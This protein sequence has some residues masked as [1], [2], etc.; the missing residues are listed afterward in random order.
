[1]SLLA[2]MFVASGLDPS[3]PERPVF[4]APAVWSG[5][6]HLVW[7]VALPGPAV[8]SASRTE[9]APPVV[10]DD[11]IL[12]GRTGVNGVLVLDRRDGVVRGTLPTSAPVAC[13]PL[14]RDGFVY[15]ADTSGQLHAFKR[16]ALDLAR[17][18]WTH[19]GGAPVLSTPVP[20]GQDLLVSNVSAVVYALDAASGQLRWRHAHALEATRA[21]A[22]PLYGA[23]A[24][25]VDTSTG[26]VYAG[27]R[28]GVVDTLDLADGEL[29]AS[30]RASEG[31]YGD[32][33]APV[34]I[35]A[36]NVVSGGFAGPIIARPAG[37]E[38][39]A[40]RLEVGN[41][42]SALVAGDALLHPGTDGKLRSVDGRTGDV[43]WTWDAG[44]DSTLSAPVRAGDVFIVGSTT[45]T[46]HMVATDGVETWAFRPDVVPNGFSASVAVDGGTMYAVSNSGVLYAF[47]TNPSSD[48]T[49]P[50]E[51]TNWPW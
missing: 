6:P 21:D 4:E 29:R 23:P 14:V 40:W 7:S 25:A 13:A 2:A 30:L 10:V 27:F 37:S 22:L 33:V 8:P 32:I 5:T 49:I 11:V 39:P 36:G 47:V 17:P 41:G 20:S 38:T 45:G 18:A 50:G 19:F 26:L 28:D 15:V 31:A 35:V 1:M 3:M 51:T 12:V 9:L 48:A 34:A 44:D 46:L 42:A 16:D 43:R 24:P